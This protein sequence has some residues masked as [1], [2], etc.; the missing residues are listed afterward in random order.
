VIAVG[1]AFEEAFASIRR[2]GRSAAISV[3]TIAIAFVALGGFLLVSVNVQ[4]AIDRWLQSAELS[5]YLTDGVLEDERAAIEAYLRTQ[6]VVVAVEFTSK[7]RALER[8]RA[9]FPEL[10]DVAS[11][12]T[13][14]PFPSSL[15][16]RLRTGVGAADEADALARSVATRAGVADVRYDRRWIER[17]LGLVAA[18]R[19][20]GAI[21][22]GILM[23]GAAFTVA[24]VVR[25]S[26]HAR[27]DEIDIMQLVGAPF[28]FIRGPSVVEGLLL[29]GAGAAV[30]LALVWLLYLAVS[31]SVG[32]QVAQAIGESGLRF[33]GLTDTFLMLA[34]G[35]AVGATAGA[36]AS[37]A[38]N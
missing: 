24:A 8:F 28:S 5:I 2:A 15:E 14:N 32:A 20:A 9:D 17:L 1:Y 38:V 3:G 23:L 18:G 7:D 11:S 26:L 33:L 31:G 6:P 16:V 13:E 19:I 37:R 34:G 12:L 36:L 4:R 30:A 22:A 25:L 21:V 29:G 35:L 10:T 27:R